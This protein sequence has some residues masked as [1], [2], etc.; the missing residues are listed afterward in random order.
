MLPAKCCQPNVVPLLNKGGIACRRPTVSQDFCASAKHITLTATVLQPCASQHERKRGS[1]V[2]A[3][4]KASEQH[5]LLHGC[6]QASSSASKLILCQRKLPKHAKTFHRNV[7]ACPCTKLSRFVKKS[8]HAKV[9]SKK[10]ATRLLLER[11]K[12]QKR[13][14][15]FT[16]ARKFPH[17]RSLT[18]VD[19]R[20]PHSHSRSLR[21]LVRVLT[22]SSSNAMRADDVKNLRSL[23]DL[24]PWK[25]KV[26]TTTADSCKSFSLSLSQT[27]TECGRVHTQ[28]W[29]R[30][31]TNELA[32]W[33]LTT[34]RFTE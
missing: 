18:I 12:G 16:L 10:Y 27:V 15:I 8:V 24:F 33:A 34:Q 14:P 29:K 6:S 23:L 17:N 28:V 26:T 21:S 3:A 4:G 1:A 9:P 13:S 20:Y 2:T 11:A 19:L 25:N 32:Y 22:Q 30:I 7:H 31:Q 5:A